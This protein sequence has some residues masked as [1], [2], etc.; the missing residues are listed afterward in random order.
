[1][2]DLSGCRLSWLDVW[3]T[4]YSLLE[5]LSEM[6]FLKSKVSPE[7]QFT[8]SKFGFRTQLTMKKPGLSVPCNCIAMFS[9]SLSRQLAD[10]SRLKSNPSRACYLPITLPSKF[11]IS[12][13]P[14][15]KTSLSA[16]A[17]NLPDTVTIFGPHVVVTPKP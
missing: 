2:Q 16:E 5:L 12:P 3:S 11:Q 6:T 14:D 17:L 15:S 13:P 9:V 10:N 8:F 7:T 1:M 4:H